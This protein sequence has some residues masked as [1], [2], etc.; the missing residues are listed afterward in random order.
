MSK[1]YLKG[2]AVSTAVIALFAAGA[3]AQPASKGT[4]WPLYGNDA[5]AQRYSPL[6]QITPENVKSL[7]V[8]WTYHMKTAGAARVATTQTT[9]LVV[10]GVMYLGSP[11]GKIVALEPTTGKEIWSVT[12]P[13]NARPAPRGMAYWPGDK[14]HAPR[15]LFGTNTGHLAAVDV[16]AGKMAEGFGENGMLNLRTP[17]IMRGYDKNYALTSPPGVYKNLVLTGASNPEEPRS[18]SG[19]ERAWDIRTG[20]LVWTFHAVPREGEFGN[21]TWPKDGWQNRSGINIWNMITID[22]KR[23]IAYLPFTGPATDRWGGD[24]HGANLFGNSLVAVDANTGKRLWHFQ[25]LHHE[26]WDW[27][28]PTPPMLFDVKKDGKTIPAVAAMNKSAYLFI[29]DRVT[30]KPIYDV[31]EVP[32]PQSNVPDEKTWP[33]QPVPVT[34]PPLAKQ[35]FT[36]ATDIATVTPELEAACKKLIADRKLT[37]TV[38]FSPITAGTQNVRFPGS[39]GGPEWGGGAFD[40]KLG[41]FIVNTQEM[42]SIEALEKKPGGWWASAYGPD[43]F[44]I[45]PDESKGY[46]PC[47]QPPWGDLWAVNVNTGKVAWRVNLGITDSFP[48]GKKNT[49]RP[50]L[51]GPLTTGSGLIFIGAT[52][53]SRF[54][55]FETKTGKEIWTTKLDAS[56]HASP[57]TYQGKDGKQYVA[58]VAT[59][60]SFVHSPPVGDSLVVFALP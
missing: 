1:R 52:D 39:G 20:K 26:V 9:P 47:Q 37:D 36:A 56:A 42:A 38:A 30:G 51:G 5:G 18:V 29:L 45:L 6:T 28:F 48:E 57:I 32:V 7:K 16:K 49:G 27:D 14:E 22:D 3:G 35:S 55:A 46:M 25:L 17:E 50:N 44:F 4:N 24:R 2:C 21:D 23:G 31:K 10:D 12:L 60:G 19:D 34:P 13:N 41:Y 15:L 11:Y 43:S 54:R 53:D 59:G 40:P 58:I 8:A 33:T